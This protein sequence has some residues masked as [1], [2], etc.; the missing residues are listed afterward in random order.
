[1]RVDNLATVN[2]QSLSDSVGPKLASVA[3]NAR[4]V[5]QDTTNQGAN[6]L[7]LI[8]EQKHL[9]ETVE[10][11]NKALEGSGRHFKYEVHKPTNQVV[12]S[13]VDDKT[14]Q[15]ITEIPAKKLLDVVGNLMELAGLFIDERR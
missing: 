12:I 13:V 8:N 3:E 1:M 6:E 7:K 5:S 2:N 15:V 11:A 9:K 10:Q 14:N 4:P